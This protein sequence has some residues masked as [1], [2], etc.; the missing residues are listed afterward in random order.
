MSQGP[1][2]NSHSA[3]L[4]FNLNLPQSLSQYELLL[5]PLQILT[6]LI[7]FFILT[8]DTVICQLLIH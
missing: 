5:P 6:E 4:I 3:S 1:Q 7:I 8:V 2:D